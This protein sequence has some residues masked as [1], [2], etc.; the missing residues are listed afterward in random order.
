MKRW[1]LVLLVLAVVPFIGAVVALDAKAGVTWSNH[2][3]PSYPHAPAAHVGRLYYHAGHSDST[4]SDD[5]GAL[6]EFLG[7]RKHVKSER[8]KV[9]HAEY[10]ARHG[11]TIPQPLR[12]YH[13]CDKWSRDAAYWRARHNEVRPH[14]SSPVHVSESLLR[15]FFNF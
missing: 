2:I 3:G 9:L 10:I 7:E 8:C 6:G 15:N 11:A 13:G 5:T 4:G 12:R 14:K 1:E